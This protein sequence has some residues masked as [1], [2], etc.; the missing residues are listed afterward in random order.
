MAEKQKT[1]LE[2]IDDALKFKSVPQQL[3]DP[4]G[5]YHL[6]GVQNVHM[7]MLPTGD[8]SMN[9]TFEKFGAA[10]TDLGYP[11]M[12]GDTTYFIFGDTHLRYRYEG[13]QKHQS[14]AYT[15]DQ[16]Y[17]DGITFDGF[18]TG[19]EGIF[20]D[21]IPCGVSGLESEVATI[22]T[23][24]F[25][26]D[27]TFYVS[28]MSVKTWS[29]AWVCNYGSFMKSTDYGKTWQRVESLTW[30]NGSSFVQNCPIRQ[31]DM[32]YVM[33]TGG[34]RDYCPSLMRVR[35]EQ[36]ED[37]SAYEYLTGYNADGTPV[38]EKG[39]D[40]M[41]QAVHFTGQCG[42][43]TVMYSEYLQE[44]LM[45]RTSRGNEVLL[46]TAKELWGP[47]SEPVKLVDGRDVH[48]PY[49]PML[50]PRYVSEG[51]KKI[52]FLLSM[53]WPL[54]NVGLYEAELLKK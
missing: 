28:F 39:D 44:W 2:I 53:F 36:F 25:F 6:A 5:R 11:V 35:K 49:A 33:G 37:R 45:A 22:P 54:Y 15:T 14:I 43:F 29:P 16:D 21:F 38:F 50:C 41:M 13:P 7:K 46:H 31:G 19:E 1:P 30:P 4:E 17:T 40:A 52:G 3:S 26:L 34:A 42:E 10:G 48:V 51:G 24:G 27:E 9:K 47:W 32:V 12:H 23:G 8:D 18:F 20:S